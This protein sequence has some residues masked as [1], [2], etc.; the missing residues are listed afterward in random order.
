MSSNIIQPTASISPISQMQPEVKAKLG[1]SVQAGDG[2]HSRQII[3]ISN[4][5]KIEIP[6]MMGSSTFVMP[7]PAN[8]YM[9]IS[10]AAVYGAKPHHEILTEEQLVARYGKDTGK[11]LQVMA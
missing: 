5:E 10:Q 8:K 6:V 9:V 1:G 11:N 7:L 2:I 4:G 3:T